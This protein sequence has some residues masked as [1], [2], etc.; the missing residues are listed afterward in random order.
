MPSFLHPQQ[1]SDSWVQHRVLEVGLSRVQIRW[2]RK[3]I[4]WRRRGRGG[5]GVSRGAQGRS[6]RERRRG[7]A[8]PLATGSQREGLDGHVLPHCSLGFE[9]SAAVQRRVC[10]RLKEIARI[11]IESKEGERGARVTSLSQRCTRRSLP[12]AW[13]LGLGVPRFSGRG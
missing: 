5:L 13:G 2:R 12:E 7:M 11:N 1:H 8:P 9:E 10:K 6:P 3:G 4:V